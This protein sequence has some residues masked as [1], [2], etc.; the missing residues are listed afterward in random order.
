MRDDKGAGTKDK[1]AVTDEPRGIA[2]QKVAVQDDKRGETND[3]G[4]LHD[5]SRCLSRRTAYLSKAPHCV[6]DGRRGFARQPACRRRFFHSLHRE[7]A[8]L[9]SSSSCA[10]CRWRASI[11]RPPSV[12]GC[13]RAS[14][15]A[16]LPTRRLQCP[17]RRHGCRA[18]VD[19]SSARPA[20]CRDRECDHGGEHCS[21]GIH[22]EVHARALLQRFARG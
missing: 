14:I 16:S 17:Q 5:E 7:I 2:K 10:T 6:H 3:K 13:G 12:V 8:R 4:V 22:R 19:G 15:G 11:A 21:A 18:P 9:P 1:A 20:A